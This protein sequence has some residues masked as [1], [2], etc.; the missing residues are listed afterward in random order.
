MWKTSLK[1]CLAISLATIC[2]LVWNKVYDLLQESKFANAPEAS[3]SNQQDMEEFTDAIWEGDLE[4]VQYMVE[5]GQDINAIDDETGDSALNTI[6]TLMYSGHKDKKHMDVIEYLL[7]NGL[8]ANVK[9]DGKTLLHEAVMYRNY[10]TI[11]KLYLHGYNMNPLDD[12]GKTP[13]MRMFEVEP[14]TSEDLITMYNFLIER[15]ADPYY[16][17]SLGFTVLTYAN[18]SDKVELTEY[19]RIKNIDGD[20][21]SKAQAEHVLNKLEINNQEEFERAVSFNNLGLVRVFL[22]AG[23]DPNV[24]AQDDYQTLIALASSIDYVEMI[25]LLLNYGADPN[26]MNDDGNTVLFY[27]AFF[28]NPKLAEILLKHGAKDTP[29]KPGYTALMIAKEDGRSEIVAML[30]NAQEGISS[31]EPEY[32]AEGDKESGDESLNYDEQTLAID[33][34]HEY[35]VEGLKAIA[36]NDFSYIESYLNPTGKAYKQSQ[37]S[38]QEANLTGKSSELI[39]YEGKQVIPINEHTYKVLTYEEYR[40]TYTS[41]SQEINGYNSEYIVVKMTNDNLALN[42]TVKVEKVFSENVV[43]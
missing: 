4:K 15:K 10:G 36:L 1:I 32:L 19:L 5:A 34:V 30:E 18:L 11:E 2:F 33:F 23:Y 24:R 22:L 39:R 35:V 7:S 9:I 28:N 26:T 3:Q 17:D 38:I 13:M 20:I 14:T 42:E 12:D 21:K 29:N 43:E 27:A 37:K 25:D 41:G 6:G 16:K 8:D 31:I 40:T